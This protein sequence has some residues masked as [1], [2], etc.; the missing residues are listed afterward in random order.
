MMYN[1]E[2]CGAVFEDKPKQRISNRQPDGFIER[3]HDGSCPY[4][5]APEDYIKELTRNDDLGD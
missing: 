2:I 5:E 4:C 3:G 1:C